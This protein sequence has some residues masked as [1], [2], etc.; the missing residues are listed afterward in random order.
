MLL[1]YYKKQLMIEKTK[2]NKS[3]E[4]IEILKENLIKEA[5]TN[6]KVNIGDKVK[7]KK[8]GNFSIEYEGFISNFKLDENNNV[9]VE[10]LKINKNGTKSKQKHPNGNVM[11]E[12]IITQLKN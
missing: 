11:L 12:E 1:D 7:I 10:I 9:T 3:K 8:Q 2:K 5:I 4:K 6:K